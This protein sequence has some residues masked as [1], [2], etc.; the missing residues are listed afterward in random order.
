MIGAGGALCLQ[1]WGR[2]LLVISLVA[3]AA[4]D[5]RGLIIAG[6]MTFR[7]R[8][9]ALTYVNG[10]WWWIFCVVAAVVMALMGKV[11]AKP[12]PMAEAGT[13]GRTAQADRLESRD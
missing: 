13:R 2:I 12:P 5:F 6:E 3:Q 10:L 1:R 4:M 7:G 9:T 11:F 8:M